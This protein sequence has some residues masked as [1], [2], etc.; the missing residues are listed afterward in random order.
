MHSV[1]NKIKTTSSQV[2]IVG[3]GPVG[4][5]SA[6]KLS[7]YG[8]K[9]V[10]LEK[11]SGPI[12]D[13]RASTFHPPTLDILAELGL[14]EKMLSLGL[15]V[16]IWQIRHLPS[17]EYVNFDLS[18]I[19]SETNHAFRLQ[20]EQKVFCRL[21]LEMLALDDAVDVRFNNEV[22]AIESNQTSAKTLVHDGNN[23]YSI[24]SDLVIAADGANS[25]CRK[26]LNIKY[27]GITYPKQSILV[28]TD[29]L[30]EDYISNLTR[31]NYLWLDNGRASF[32]RLKEYWRC[33]LYPNVTNSQ[34]V[35]EDEFINSE[36]NKIVPGVTFTILERG[37]YYLHRKIIDNYVHGRVVFAGDSAHLINPTGGMGMNSG[38]HDAIFL[39]EMIEKIINGKESMDLLSF[40]STQRREIM[41]NI[42]E[43]SDENRGR[44]QNKNNDYRMAEI[45]RMQTIARD[46]NKLKEYLL[47]TSMIA[48]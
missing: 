4:L 37:K 15:K 23:E 30:F 22:V 45:K 39:T 35:L 3:A 9:C 40:Y 36:L 8:I 21:C 29:F 42:M 26:H 13:I 38:I 24:K 6:M 46:D 19:Q 20:L 5:V 14:M 11:N 7:K 31:V 16:P 25:F 28:A 47:K 44:L 18:L 10:V 1:K 33:A 48:G 43:L 17:G 2:V 12:T 27:V 34:I 32:L 41:G